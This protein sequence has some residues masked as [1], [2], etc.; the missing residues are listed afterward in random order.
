V[1]VEIDENQHNTYQDS[2]ECSRINEIVNG[3]GGKP[4]II[5]R[6]NPDVFRVNDKIVNVSDK[7]RHELLLRWVKHYLKNGTE[8]SLEVKYL[9]YDEYDEACQKKITITESDII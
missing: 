1:I 6:Y 7:K 2:C 9:F 5:I 3:I 4:V 8:F